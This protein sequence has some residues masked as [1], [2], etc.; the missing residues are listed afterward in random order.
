MK[1]EAEKKIA[2]YEAEVL[3]RERRKAAESAPWN[4]DIF[5]A[6][7]EVEKMESE[8]DVAFAKAKEEEEAQIAAQNR[9]ILR[10]VD[11]VEYLKKNGKK[12]AA[13]ALTGT[14]VVAAA[15]ISKSQ[16]KKAKAARKAAIIG[17]IREWL[18]VFR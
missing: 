7:S 8:S 18:S 16:Q 4:M 3:A 11:T 13:V 5:D 2:E 12:I 10:G 15:A 14:A 9:A 17:E 6:T 1:L